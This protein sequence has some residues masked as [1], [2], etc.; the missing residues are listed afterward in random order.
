MTFTVPTT[1]TS[2]PLTISINGVSYVLGAGETVDI[3]AEIATEISRMVASQNH[4]PPAVNPPFTN[5]EVNRMLQ[6]ILT[7][8]AAVETAAAIK[9][10]P[11]SPETAGSY[12]LQVT[13]EDGDSTLSWEAVESSSSP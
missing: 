11:D 5:A 6:S 10:L 1:I 12:A 3:P 4:D 13:V 7:R 8:L 9:E 2:D